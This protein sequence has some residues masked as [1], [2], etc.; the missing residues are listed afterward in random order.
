M[1]EFI[2]LMVVLLIVFIFFFRHRSEDLWEGYPNTGNV[3]RLGLVLVGAVEVIADSTRYDSALMHF[4]LLKKLNPYAS[5]ISIAQVFSGVC[6]LLVFIHYMRISVKV[7]GFSWYHI[8]AIL[9]FVGSL[10]GV[11]YF[12]E[13]WVQRSAAYV[14][15]YTWMASSLLVLVLTVTAIYKTCV[16]KSYKDKE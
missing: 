9:L 7:N 16:A 15:C 12:G 8:F 10:V 13:Y 2:L 14:E 11:G 3:A 1:L 6:I 4:F 5:F